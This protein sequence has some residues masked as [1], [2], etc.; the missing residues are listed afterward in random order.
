[1]GYYDALKKAL[2]EAKNEHDIGVYL[3]QN[4][5]LIRVLNE[6]SWN[7]VIAKPEFKIGTK[8]RSDFIVLSACSGYWNCVLIEMQSPTD[9]IFNKQGEVST[10]L[11]EAQRQLQ[12]WEMYIDENGTSF[13]EQLATLAGDEPAHCS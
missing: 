1:M 7:C 5:R 4:I 10:G 13:R 12:E 11:K 6:H 3:K 8:Y 2:E 9:K